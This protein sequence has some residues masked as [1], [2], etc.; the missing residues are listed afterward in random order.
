MSNEDIKRHALLLASLKQQ[1]MKEIVSDM[2]DI[3][4]TTDFP[5]NVT[6]KFLI[7]W[8]EGLEKRL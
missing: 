6:K 5:R 2:K 8:L 3:I 7:D 4:Q 1:A